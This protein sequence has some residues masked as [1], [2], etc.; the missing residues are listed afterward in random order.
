MLSIS[1]GASFFS[2][3]FSLTGGL[4]D[5]LTSGLVALISGLAALTSGLAALTSGLT[6]ETGF[7]A[8]TFETLGATGSGCL[9]SS[10]FDCDNNGS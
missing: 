10:L 6:S 7:D 2:I 5:A 4:E 3:D 9:V 8:F 1:I